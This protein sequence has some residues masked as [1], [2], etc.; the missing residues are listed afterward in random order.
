MKFVIRQAEVADAAAIAV[1]LREAFEPYRSQYTAGAFADTVPDEAGIQDRLRTMT[2][3]VAFNPTGEI[4]GTVAAHAQMSDIGHLR[5]MAVRKKWQGSGVA[6]ELLA[7]AEE[8][9]RDRGC[10]LITLDTTRPLARAIRF[11]E[12]YGFVATG[13]VQDFFGMPLFEYTK[14]VDTTTP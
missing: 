10:N 11:Y 3:F 7:A 12:R 9:L 8:F 4:V 5:G 6:A 1:C 13:R 2:C 14:R